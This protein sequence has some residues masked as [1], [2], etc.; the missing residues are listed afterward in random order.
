MSNILLNYGL[1]PD[2]LKLKERKLLF[3]NYKHFYYIPDYI[4]DSKTHTVYIFDDN[5]IDF[6]HNI[7]G[8][9]IKIFK[10][11]ELYSFYEKYFKQYVDG[12]KTVFAHKNEFELLN[13]LQEVLNE[14]IYF[15]DFI[16]NVDDEITVLSNSFRF[17]D[18]DIVQ[19]K[20]WFYY[21][22]ILYSNCLKEKVNYN[23]AYGYFNFTKEKYERFIEISKKTFN[24]FF[25]DEPDFDFDAE[26]LR[27]NML[28][29]LKMRP[30]SL[31]LKKTYHKNFKT[32][33]RKPHINRFHYGCKHILKELYDI[34]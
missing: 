3:K 25:D 20:N 33:G 24:A 1:V 17:Y 8:S 23:I 30:I 14:Y 28:S 29:D 19:D 2:I 34:R 16:N 12:V 31:K 10:Y 15:Y 26:R 21:N 11:R 18:E 32:F 7:L 5:D 22:R 4:P 6:I 9:N 27:Y 13:D